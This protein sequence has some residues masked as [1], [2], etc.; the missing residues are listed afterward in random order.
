[1]LGHL[2]NIHKVTNKHIIALCKFYQHMHIFKQKKIQ[3]NPKMNLI[4]HNE[5]KFFKTLI[6]F[7]IDSACILKWK[8]DILKLFVAFNIDQ[9]TKLLEF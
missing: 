3:S 8:G 9:V 5:F 1:M 2:D 7:F 6:S 4:S